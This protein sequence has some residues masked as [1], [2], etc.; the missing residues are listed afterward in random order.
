[1]TWG[2]EVTSDKRISRTPSPKRIS[3]TSSFKKQQMSLVFSSRALQQTGEATFT[4]LLK[5]EQLRI[6]KAFIVYEPGVFGGDGS[7][8]RVNICIKNDAA[9][10]KILEMEEQNLSQPVSSCVKEADGEDDSGYIK[11]K[12]DLDKARFF[13]ASHE[14]IEKPSRLIGLCCNVMLSIKGK[15]ESRGQQG[16]SLLV[17]DIQ[18]LDGVSPFQN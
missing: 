7:E 2:V 14:K 5:W 6:N 10:A 12:I 16:L 18:V 9:V 3:R 8:A 4:P 11:A 13:N 15:W 17:T 1:M